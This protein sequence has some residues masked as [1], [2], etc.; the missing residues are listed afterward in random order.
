MVTDGGGAGVRKDSCLTGVVTLAPAYI[1]SVFNG[2]KCLYFLKHHKELL[3]F[4]LVSS[5]VSYINFSVF[6]PSFL[7]F[8]H[9]TPPLIIKVKSG[10]G[11]VYMIG[12]REN[13]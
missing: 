4:F 10:Y 5:F 13:C 9:F 6:F 8:P 7:N 2:F 12:H 11:Q 1:V 3:S